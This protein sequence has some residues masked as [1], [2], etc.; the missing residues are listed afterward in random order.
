[1]YDGDDEE[2]Y[3]S[4]CVDRRGLTRR[5]DKDLMRVCPAHDTRQARLSAFYGL[6]STSTSYEM[7]VLAPTKAGSTPGTAS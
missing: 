6:V 1:V 7:P 5:A 3:I 2:P 4:T